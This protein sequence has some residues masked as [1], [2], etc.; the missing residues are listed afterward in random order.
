M[1]SLARLVIHPLLTKADPAGETLEE[2][3]AFRQLPQCRC[4]PRRKQAE[5]AGI[6]GDFLARPPVNERI[7]RLDSDPAQPRLTLAACRRGC[8]HRYRQLRWRDCALP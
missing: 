4:R 8:H 3:V 7:E 5:V 1:N 6:L 2:A